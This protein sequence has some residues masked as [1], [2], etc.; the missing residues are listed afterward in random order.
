MKRIALIVTILILALTLHAQEQIKQGAYSLGGS[1]F[2]SSSSINYSSYDYNQSIY[3]ISPIGSY[4]IIDQ[5]EI[6]FGV[7]YL[8]SKS[9]STLSSSYYYSGLGY[10]ETGSYES[11]ST[12]LS[13][14][15]GLA[16]YIPLGNI[17]PFIGTGGGVSWTKSNMSANSETFSPPRTKY[18]FVGG[19]EI[20]ISQV[21]SIEPAVMY[22]E[23]RRSENVSQ[24]IIM[25][26]VGVRYFIY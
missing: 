4:F 23:I 14:S 13:I 20:F 2:Y 10:I 3:A 11:K 1:I 22:T 12:D 21:A 24:N 19:L 25:V 8:Y 26:G 6:S 16:Y 7:S 17:S 15:L 18:Y 5:V 9:Y